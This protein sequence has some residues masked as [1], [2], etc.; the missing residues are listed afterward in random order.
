MLMEEIERMSELAQ[1]QLDKEN[2]SNEVTKQ[3]MNIVE[4]FIASSRVMCYGG[5]AINNLL[6]DK[7]KFYDPV[8]DIPDY[9]MFS[10]N[11]QLHAMELA[12]K[13]A[14][15]KVKTVEVKPGMHPGTYKVFAN[16]SGVADITH[17]TNPLFA[18]LW[19]KS[20]VKDR[21]HYVPP[22]FL[23]MSI[24]MELSRPRGDVSRWSKVYSRLLLLNKHHPI[25]CPKN[26][27]EITDVLVP[28][29]IRNAIENLIVDEKLVLLGFN[30]STLHGTKGAGK[31]K[32]PIDVLAESDK[33][34][35]VAK[36]FQTILNKV[37]KTT[38]KE[39]E[40]YGEI[41][42]KYSDVTDDS[43]GKVAVRVYE[44]LYCH[45]YHETPKGLRIASIPTL[46]QFFLSVFYG[47]DE[48]REGFQ[49]QRYLCT[50]EHLL[51]LAE[52]SGDRKYSLLTPIECIGK[53]AS[54]S[55]IKV[56]RA[57]DYEKLSKDRNSKLYL[58]SFFT[59]DPSK[60]TAADKKKIKEKLSKIEK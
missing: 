47:D 46:L 54:L 3:M 29:K 41:L 60:A 16:L 25:V 38:I 36:K 55:D 34:E 8:T 45:S 23:R 15:S 57:A 43:S 50:A 32:L 14:K 26:Y 12:D 17:L 56:K 20:V 9:D 13:L 2:A 35:S 52:E 53:Q 39:Y 18:K 58:E 48:I 28:T 27:Q 44:T 6:P 30:A 51:E 31:W 33:R 40:G 5:T 24:Y 4:E 37:G 49:E 21:L 19:D 11:P 59:Y 7:D 42:P 1:S 22:N 10:E